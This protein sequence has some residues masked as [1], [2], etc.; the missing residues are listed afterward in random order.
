MPTLCR[1]DT[2]GCVDDPGCQLAY[3]NQKRIATN[4]YKNIY[5]K[6]LK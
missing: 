3:A 2:R 5:L 1:Y 6:I 4:R